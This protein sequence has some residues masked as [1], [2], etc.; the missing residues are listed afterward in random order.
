MSLSEIRRTVQSLRR[1]LALPL[2]VIRA[3]RITERVCHRWDVL[4]DQGQ[5]LPGP[6]DALREINEERCPPADF[7]ALNRYIRRCHERDEF[8]DAKEMVLAMLPRA[9]RHGLVHHCF[10]WD[11]GGL[12][13]PP[14]L[15]ERARMRVK[16][17]VP[18]T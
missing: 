1:Q 2:A 9:A 3:R 10:R 6:F 12:T 11:L 5:P 17:Q 15:R 4:R 8:P 14:P 13:Q 16:S 18:S 7:M